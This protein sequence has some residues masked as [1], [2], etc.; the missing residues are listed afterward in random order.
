MFSRQEI[1]DG[2][3]KSL[4]RGILLHPRYFIHSRILQSPR[5]SRIIKKREDQI[6]NFKI[7]PKI[8]KKSPRCVKNQ[9][10]RDSLSI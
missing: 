7:H 9:S 1:L 2:A 10:R 8:I 4:R 3:A 5:N 6:K